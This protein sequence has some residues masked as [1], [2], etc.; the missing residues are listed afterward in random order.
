MSVITY[1]SLLSVGGEIDQRSLVTQVFN[2]I[3]LKKP[4]VSP[5]E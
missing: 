4:D 1:N 2:D 5:F 3:R